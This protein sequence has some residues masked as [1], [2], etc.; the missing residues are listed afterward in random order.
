MEQEGWDTLK[1]YEMV[2]LVLYYAVPRQNLTDI[3]RLLVSHFKTVG[4]VFSATREQLMEVEGM[5]PAMT[6]CI[7]TT[8]ELMRAY[9]DLHAQ[10]CLRLS[11][12]QEDF[13]FLESRIQEVKNSGFWVIYADYDH[14]LITFTDIWEYDVWWHSENVRRM[15]VESI[16]YGARYIFLVKYTEG[17]AQEMDEQES[18]QV[19]SVSITLS[20]VGVDLLDYVLIGE[21]GMHSMHADGKMN[22]TRAGTKKMQLNE[23]Y[24]GAQHGLS[25]DI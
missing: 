5:T 24:I 21:D 23:G 14:N 12:Y 1:P 16:K 17:A 9:Y 6:E 2:E 25:S 11:C 4:G 20:A 15:V 8:G 13:K 22:N 10:R 18:E 19:N 3:S 7:L